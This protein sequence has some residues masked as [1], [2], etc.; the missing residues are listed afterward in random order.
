MLRSTGTNSPS[1]VSTAMPKWILRQQAAAERLAVEPRVQRGLG[2]A[3]RGDRAD[4]TQHQLACSPATTRARSASSITVTGATSACACA[5]L[6]AIVR[7][8]PRN[9]SS[10]PSFAEDPGHS[11]DVAHGHRVVRPARRHDR[12]V[13][14]EPARERPD[15]GCRLDRGRAGPPRR[16]GALAR[17]PRCPSRRGRRRFRRRRR[18]LAGRVA[19][20]G[21]ALEFHERCADL[22]GCR[23]AH[24][25]AA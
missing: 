21:A 13:H 19:V 18:P 6:C 7:R 20:L 24:R 16:S 23:R 8:T 22:A 9:G 2:P 15:G 4:Q 11:L 14:V 3:A 1:G 10:G 5:M 25:T 17:A 12:E